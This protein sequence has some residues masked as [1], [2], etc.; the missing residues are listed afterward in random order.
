MIT[1]ELSSYELDIEDSVLGVHG[2]LVLRSLTDQTLLV[3]ERDEGGGGEATLLVGNC[4][5]SVRNLAPLVVCILISTLL[6]S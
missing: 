4:E 3:G 5:R 2:G 1:Q 6:P